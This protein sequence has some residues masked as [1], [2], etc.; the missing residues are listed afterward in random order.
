[1]RI[2]E[3][4]E[5]KLP[6]LFDEKDNPV[7]MTQISSEKLALC[8]QNGSQESFVELVR[9]YE[10]RLLNFMKYKTGNINDA[11][12]LVQ[13]T[14]IKAYTN[15]QKYRSSFKFST[16]LFTIAS[17][18]AASHYRK[19]KLNVSRQEMFC[20]NNQLS[21]VVEK[22]TNCNLL[23]LASK[24]PENQYQALWLKYVEDMS[25]KEISQVM[26][27]SQVNVKVLLYRARLNLSR[28]LRR[29]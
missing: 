29:S 27:K 14:F 23:L 21:E 12:D 3:Q 20:E 22:E 25:V 10:G 16:W 7:V 4:K 2:K 1:M 28:L 15:I 24:L 13:E 19:L 11:E 17:R 6:K 9:R 26:R 8:V 18:L 5:Y